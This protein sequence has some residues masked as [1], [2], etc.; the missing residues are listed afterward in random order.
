MKISSCSI[1]SIRNDHIVA[2]AY[3][4]KM[5]QNGGEIIESEAASKNQRAK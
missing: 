2:K 1:E 4:A 5:A 3:Q